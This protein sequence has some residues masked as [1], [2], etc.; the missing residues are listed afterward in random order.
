MIYTETTGCAFFY[1]LLLRHA[2]SPS[3]PR[4]PVSLLRS[5]A[6]LMNYA[7]P[8]VFVR[9]TMTQGC[10]QLTPGIKK[11]NLSQKR[12]ILTAALPCKLLLNTTESLSRCCRE[13][14]E[15]DVVILNNFFNIKCHASLKAKPTGESIWRS[16]HTLRHRHTHS[17]VFKHHG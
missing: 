7:N 1:L 12:I 2:R 10:K 9:S 5:T 14:R 4:T 3:M 17:R 15:W 16:S 11:A 6:T 13:E 8:L